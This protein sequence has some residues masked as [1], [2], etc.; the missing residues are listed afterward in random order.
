MNFEEYVKM[1]PEITKANRPFWDGCAA[2]ELRLQTCKKCGFHRYPDS[3]LCPRCLSHDSEWLKV[4]GKGRVW[5]WVIMHQKYFDAFADELPYAV[6]L[7]ELEEGPRIMSGLVGDPNE[8][9]I[10]RMVEVTFV[11][12]AEQRVIPKFRMVP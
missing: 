9:Q 8:L 4:S 2:G 12:V 7:V 11:T 3:D 1:L 5:S 6:L 10:D